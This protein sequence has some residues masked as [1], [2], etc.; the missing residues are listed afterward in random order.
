MALEAEAYLSV[1]GMITA[2]VIVATLEM[3]LVQLTTEVRILVVVT[4]GQWP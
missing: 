3:V 1:P 4:E 2:E